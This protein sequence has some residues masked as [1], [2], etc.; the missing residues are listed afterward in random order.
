[1]EQFHPKIPGP[2]KSIRANQALESSVL[3]AGIESEIGRFGARDLVAM[4]G[5]TRTLEDDAGD[6]HSRFT[7]L[8]ILHTAR[9]CMCPHKALYFQEE[10]C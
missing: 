6:L 10:G 4:R 9:A 5:K 3:S 8:P 7:Q 2:K 1:M